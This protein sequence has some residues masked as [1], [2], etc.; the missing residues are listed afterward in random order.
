MPI[1]VHGAP[2]AV[3]RRLPY[4]PRSGSHLGCRSFTR[5]SWWDP[6]PSSYPPT[7]PLSHSPTSRHPALLS[8]GTMYDNTRR[9]PAAVS[10]RLPFFLGCRGESAKKVG[11]PAPRTYFVPA[12]LL[13]S[14]HVGGEREGASAVAFLER[15]SL[16]SE[17]QMGRDLVCV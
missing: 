1:A 6:P 15:P 8:K 9:T 3:R 5:G 14:A 7:H 16:V 2:T 4:G 13:S 17:A 11:R 12:Y 10:T